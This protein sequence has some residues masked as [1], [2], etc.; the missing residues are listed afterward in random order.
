MTNEQ[1]KQL[2]T[3]IQDHG[4]IRSKPRAQFVHF[5]WRGVSIKIDYCLKHGTGTGRVV[6]VVSFGDEEFP[7]SIDDIDD[8]LFATLVDYKMD[9]EDTV[10]DISKLVYEINKE[11]I[12][13]WD[14]KE[15][16]D[17]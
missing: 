4:A 16:N 6:G 8:M 12:K 14:K 3:L 2:L 9:M 17:D 1:R 13:D 10:K 7:E 11:T 5:K 15:A